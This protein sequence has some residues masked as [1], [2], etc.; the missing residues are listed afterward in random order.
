MMPSMRTLKRA[1][2]NVR[3][4]T[5]TLHLPPALSEIYGGPNSTWLREVLEY[6][7]NLQSLIVSQLPFFDH[8]ALLALR[9]APSSGEERRERESFVPTYGLRL[10]LAASEPNTTST[11]IAEALTHFPRLVYLDLSFTRPAKDVSVLLAIGS[12]EDLRVLKLRGIGLRDAE[13]EILAN[14][15]STKVRV[16]DLRNN[17]LTDAAIRSIVQACVLPPN[18]THTH[19]H[20]L[21]RRQTFEDWPIGLP[22]GPELL[23]LDVLRGANLD[24]NLQ[25]QLTNPL[26][27]RLAIEDI[28]PKG[29]THFYI[30]DNRLSVEGLSG[31]LKSSRL[32]V[33]DAGSVDTANVLDNSTP[34]SNSRSRDSR[35]KLPGPEKAIP[36]LQK[37]AGKSLTYLRVNHAVVTKQAASKD[38]A[39]SGPSELPKGDLRSE[40]QGSNSLPLEMESNEAHIELPAEIDTPRAELA[41][42]CIHFT[43]SQPVNQAPRESDLDKVP[44]PIRGDGAFAPEPLSEEDLKES[45]GNMQH[46]EVILNAT[47]S[48]LSAGQPKSSSSSSAVTS[49]AE[50]Q[51]SET[52]TMSS[53]SPKSDFFQAAE[54][55]RLMRRRS[56]HSPTSNSATSNLVFS[57]HPSSLPHLQTLVLTDVPTQVPQS[58]L[59]IPALKAFVS[60][61]ADEAQLAALKAQT[62]YS[63]P[64]GTGRMNAEHAH[65]KTLF[66]LS[67]IILE[68]SPISTVGANTTSKAAG[69]GATSKLSPWVQSYN[70]YNSGKSSTGDKDSE[71]LWN[72]AESDFSFFGEEGEEENENGIYENEPEKYFPMAAQNEKIVLS[73]EDTS[74]PAARS[75][76]GVSGPSLKSPTLL[77]SP[78]SLPL[79]K[80]ATS[81]SSSRTSFEGP[82]RPAMSSTP[83]NDK[84][85]WTNNDTA[86]SPGQVDEPL[87]NV[88]AELAKFRKGRKAK[89]EAALQHWRT[90]H[91][92]TSSQTLTSGPTRSPSPNYSIRN[93]PFVE[94]HWK[95]DVKVVRNAAPKGRSGL[96]DI[97]GNYFE[98]GYLYP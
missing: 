91:T 5:H 34:I 67:T 65:A 14:A 38:A 82:E 40:L 69:N 84:S 39:Y 93:L 86:R 9:H 97:Y 37:Y 48:G 31:L 52:G 27:G 22:L 61:C 7:P 70:P 62:N 49:L 57:L 72:A 16:L 88:V 83:H 44:V 51:A 45:T 73:S 89:H 63:L 35:L 23:S 77:P 32:H 64:P 90:S 66:A 95:G 81:A 2:F 71:N 19:I 50:A 18:L 3:Q 92:R 26:T 20:P 53:N 46:D 15:I 79:R 10:L 54:I 13:A 56:L 1:R 60:A 25:V 87:V 30:A 8:H 4:L 85:Q 11:S 33:L 47:G 59:L 12:L 42:D 36:I 94:G 28:P 43:L 80:R 76:L 21:F 96:V 41:G 74:M 78:R 24:E 55:E 6:L 68:M 58:S 29:L 75:E 98:K 17:V